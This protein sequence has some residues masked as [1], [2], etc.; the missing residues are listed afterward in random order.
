VWLAPCG[1]LR[2]ICCSWLSGSSPHQEYPHWSLLR[3]RPNQQHSSSG[4]WQSQR[5]YNNKMW[6]KLY[7]SMNQFVTSLMNI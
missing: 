6:S 7:L 3:G 2:W 1:L 4:G 5:R